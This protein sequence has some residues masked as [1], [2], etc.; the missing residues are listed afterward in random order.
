MTQRRLAKLLGV[1]PATVS[2]W[3]SGATS[4]ELRLLPRVLDY[5]GRDPR[6]EPEPDV[7]GALLRRARTAAGISIEELAR[8][9]SVDPTTI[10]KW[11]HGRNRPEI[12]HRARIR[13][14]AGTEQAGGEL[15]E[16]LGTRSRAYREQYGLRQKDLARMIGVR[17]QDVSKWERGASAPP[18]AVRD[19][20][21]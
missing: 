16:R 5:L 10:W 12:R 3:E 14:L 20:L 11:E 19:L 21:A 18:G 2:N 17:Q 13:E 8:T 6:P 1:H 4:P 15:S 9:W 7:L